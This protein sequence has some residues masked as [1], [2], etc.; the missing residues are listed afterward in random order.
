MQ[1][2]RI[3]IWIIFSDSNTTF[4]NGDWQC[5]SLEEKVQ[6]SEI[7]MMGMHMYYFLLQHNPAILPQHF[8]KNPFPLT[9]P[10]LTLFHHFV[11]PF[12]V[13]SLAVYMK[14]ST[15]RFINL[16]STVI[17]SSIYPAL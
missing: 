9:N 13:F 16:L 1:N 15:L 4:D 3:D 10:G 11:S 7:G 12:S 14:T 6:C 5:V 17:I 8:F 2:R